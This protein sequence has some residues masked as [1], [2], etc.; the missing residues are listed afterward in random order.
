MNSSTFDRTFGLT[1]FQWGEHDSSN[2]EAKNG[3]GLPIAS[4]SPILFH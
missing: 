2:Q 4:I 3:M 1:K